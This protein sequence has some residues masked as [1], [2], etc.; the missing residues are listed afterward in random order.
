MEKEKVSSPVGSSGKLSK[1]TLAGSNEKY[2]VKSLV[3]KASDFFIRILASAVVILVA[4]LILRGNLLSAI[5]LDPASK[6]EKL[7]AGNK[8][9]KGFSNDEFRIYYAETED[10]IISYAF[11]KKLGVWLQEYPFDKNNRNISG[12]SFGRKHAY[13]YGNF[14]SND[15][16]DFITEAKDD[17]ERIYPNITDLGSKKM[18]VYQIPLNME[19]KMSYCFVDNEDVINREKLFLDG[20][21]RFYKYTDGKT[22]EYYSTIGELKAEKSYLWELIEKCFESADTSNEIIDG[23]VYKSDKPEDTIWRIYVSYNTGDFINL[24]PGRK[25]YDWTG[26]VSFDIELKGQ[27]PGTIAM[28]WRDYTKYSLYDKVSGETAVYSVVVPE[29]LYAYFEEL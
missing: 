19:D 14:T 27:H 4:N 8:I 25:G 6:V 1:G 2:T 28:Y 7:A 12:I 23:R 10:G 21:V 5:T 9:M 17:G 16:Y 18:V 11:I 15:E 13:Y 22:T 3:K 24:E 29:E 20:E 26:K